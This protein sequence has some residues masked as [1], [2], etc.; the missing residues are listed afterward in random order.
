M[1][2]VLRWCICHPTLY[3]R[4]DAGDG[5]HPMVNPPDHASYA[6]LFSQLWQTVAP[7]TLQPETS[8][9]SQQTVR[10]AGPPVLFGE[11]HFWITSN[12]IC[13]MLPHVGRRQLPLIMQPFEYSTMLSRGADM[14]RTGGPRPS[15][16]LCRYANIDGCA[17]SCIGEWSRMPL[18]R[19]VRF[20]RDYRSL[21]S[22]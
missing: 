7:N 20:I 6:Y 13:S 12:M 16:A 21:F 2:E 10:T 3:R 15:H 4:I 11:T 22:S 5:R 1:L 19:R 8:G 14:R 18:V 9:T 17:R